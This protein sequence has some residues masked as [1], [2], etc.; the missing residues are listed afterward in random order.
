MF[1]CQGAG[2]SKVEKRTRVHDAS[3]GLLATS[4]RA[5]D[6]DT[7]AQIAGQEWSG[8]SVFY[9]H[10]SGKVIRLTKGASHNVTLKVLEY[11]L[12]Q[13]CPVQVRF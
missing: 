3:P 9:A 12:F 2:W 6:V 13:I 1:N 4:V 7:I 5:T 8:D 11:E 10:R